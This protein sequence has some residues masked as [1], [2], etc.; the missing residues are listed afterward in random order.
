VFHFLICLFVCFSNGWSIGSS[1]LF[2]SRTPKISGYLCLS[3]MSWYVTGGDAGQEAP[4]SPDFTLDAALDELTGQLS[5]LAQA[6]P[7]E[8]LEVTALST[9]QNMKEDGHYPG[10]APA[11]RQAIRPV[12][13]DADCYQHNLLRFDLIHGEYRRLDRPVLPYKDD[14]K[15][16]FVVSRTS[17]IMSSSPFRVI[18][19]VAKHLSRRRSDTSAPQQSAGQKH[20]TSTTTCKA[21]SKK[22][23]TEDTP[24]E[25]P[26]ATSTTG[27]LTEDTRDRAREQNGEKGA[28]ASFAAP[29]KDL[30]PDTQLVLQ[31]RFNCVTQYPSVAIQFQRNGRTIT[32]LVYGSTPMG[33]RASW[34]I[35][36]RTFVHGFDTDPIVPKVLHMNSA[37]MKAALPNED[38][39]LT[40]QSR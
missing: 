7:L 27:Q 33:N 24:T 2:A 25:A 15:P 39:E 30:P 32:C 26:G 23:K 31:V 3:F 8:V 16:Q 17:F 40:L 9:E 14:G 6:A 36:Y 35:K 19:S 21:E 22:S 13:Q 38:Q 20:E 11:Y 1:R 28:S 34:N 5:G 4:F 18:S 12:I 10:A 37:E 29:L